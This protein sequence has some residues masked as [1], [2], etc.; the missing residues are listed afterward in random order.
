MGRTGSASIFA[1]EH[2]NSALAKDVKDA[3]GAGRL[4][5]VLQAYDWG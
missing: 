2:I 1:A 3:I 5:A 4:A